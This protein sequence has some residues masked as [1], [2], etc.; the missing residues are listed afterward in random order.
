MSK[1]IKS[2]LRYP[3]GKSRAIEQIHAHL[4]LHIQEYREP[5]IG[6]GS[7]FLSVKGIFNKHI[8]RYWINDIHSDLTCF[9]KGLRDDPTALL[10]RLWHYKHHYD[11]GRTLY[12]YFK[13]E[14]NTQTDLARAVRFFV[15]NRITF[16]G[17]MDAGGYSEQAFQKRFTD[18]SIERLERIIPILQN[19]HI[20]QFDYETLLFAEGEQVF[21]FLDPPYYS[22]TK[23]RLYGKR[24]ELHTMF[25]HERFADAMQRCSHRWLITYDDSPMI[26]SLFSFADI[27]AWQLQYGMNNYKQASAAKGN[28]L[29]IRNY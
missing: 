25:D 2:P 5:F 8:Q 29:F 26:R 27:S 13:D 3:G 11:D 15:M 9:W 4:P 28:E 17:V 16:S 21:I 23:S 14:R 1:I 24:G 7:V 18:S 19:T 10:E 20:T 12:N 6:G 22:A